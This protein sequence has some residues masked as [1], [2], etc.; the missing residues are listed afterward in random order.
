MA[1]LGT[2]RQVLAF[3]SDL[4]VCSQGQALLV[5]SGPAPVRQCPILP[6]SPEGPREAWC[7][8]LVSVGGLGQLGRL[9]LSVQATHYCVAQILD[10]GAS[11]SPPAA[12]GGASGVMTLGR[13]SWVL[14]GSV[15]GLRAGGRREKPS[16]RHQAGGAIRLASILPQPSVR[17][18]SGP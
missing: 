11:C 17:H 1:P 13:R 12:G 4:R 5:A 7:C 10:T 18:L 15:W 3:C 6:P 16:H 14:P 8:P 9:S 2:L